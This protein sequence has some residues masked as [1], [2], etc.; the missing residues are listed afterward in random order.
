MQISPKNIVIVIVVITLIFLIVGVAM[1]M[2]VRLYNRRRRKD[3]EEKEKMREQFERQL[4]QVQ[5]EV[6]EATKSALST[7]LHDNVGQL[8]STTKMLLGITQRGMET[9]PDTFV[10]AHETLATAILELRTLSKAL[11]KE[12]LEQF[13]L[14][15]NLMTEVSRINQSNTFRVQVDLPRILP[16]PPN[17][18]II[19]YRVIQ[20]G[21]QNAIKHAEAKTLRISITRGKNW[22]VRIED[23]GKGL[24]TSVDGMGIS[25]MRQR[26][27]LIGGSINWQS[28]VGTGTA[29]IIHLPLKNES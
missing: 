3:S 10:T 11:D 8:L 1:V 17:E 21:L 6:Q 20:E 23:D 2:Y 12:W 24:A 28:A 27:Q 15:E 22:V 14:V 13:S 9:V 18:Q 16:L 25:N 7:E 29:I 5:V 26:I 4:F 19:L